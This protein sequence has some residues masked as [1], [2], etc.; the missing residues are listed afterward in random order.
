MTNGN[1]QVI[2][3]KIVRDNSRA[4]GSGGRRRHTILVV[5]DRVE[6]I[7]ELLMLL[8]DTQHSVTFN[9]IV[10]HTELYSDRGESSRKSFERDKSLLRQ[11]GIEITTE[12]DRSN[13]STRYRVRPEDYFLPDL[14]LTESERLALQLAASVVRLDEAWDEQALTKLGAA[15]ATPPFVV[16]EIPALEALP[17]IYA[18]VRD[19][20]PVRFTYS[21]R[22]RE[23]SCYGVFYRDGNWYLAGDDAGTVKVFRV[24]RV[25]GTVGVGRSG[26]YEIPDDFD[27]SD[28]MPKDPL[29]IGGDDALEALVWVDSTLANRIIGLRGVENVR[30]RRDDG[31]VVVAV[32]V[33]NRDAFRSWVLG[34]R[35]HAEVMSPPELRQDLV[36]WLQELI[37]AN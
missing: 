32:P 10:H 13:G 17:V 3:G 11:L 5:D 26:S 14:D 4:R 18:A 30:D 1:S 7:T 28:T 20:A 34:L 36:D 8:L 22:A 27:L 15:G 33:R 23:V 12:I 35:H 2:F 25:E 9:H 37:G 6:R 19:R 29:M 31:S 16:A 24:D 21:D